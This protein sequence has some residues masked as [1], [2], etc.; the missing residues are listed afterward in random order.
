VKTPRMLIRS[1]QKVITTSRLARVP[2]G[3]TC[4]GSALRGGSLA[5][6]AKRTIR[7]FSKENFERTERQSFDAISG[8][9]ARAK[10][11]NSIRGVIRA[12]GIVISLG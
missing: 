7:I 4:A 9:A 1:H 11:A 5:L 10:G 2:L 8:I 6:R 3:V 12:D